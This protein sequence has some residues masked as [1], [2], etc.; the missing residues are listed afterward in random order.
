MIEARECEEAPEARQSSHPHFRLGHAGKRLEVEPREVRFGY[1]AQL[2]VDGQLRDDRTARS[3]RAEL[4]ADDVTGQLRWSDFGGVK[5]CTLVAKDAAGKPL[6]VPFAPPPGSQAFRLAQLKRANPVLYAACH[7]VKPVLQALVPLL[8]IG[9]L[10]T[11]LLSQFDWTWLPPFV[12]DKLFGDRPAWLEPMLGSPFFQVGKW[13]APIVFALFVTL[14][15][16][17]KRQTHV[18]R[19]EA[20]RGPHR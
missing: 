8:G 10:L 15:E 14:D 12:R 7:L 5:T 1:R 17:E 3:Q 19:E 18:A 4:H 2:F 16:Y 11:A 9:A 6:D 13:L 20:I